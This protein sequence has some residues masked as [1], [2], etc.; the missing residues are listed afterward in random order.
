MYDISLDNNLY[1]LALIS[2]PVEFSSGRT[3]MKDGLRKVSVFVK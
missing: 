2:R 3:G 1:L